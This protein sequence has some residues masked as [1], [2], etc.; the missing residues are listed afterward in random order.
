MAFYHRTERARIAHIFIWVCVLITMASY[1]RIVR[2]AHGAHLCSGRPVGSQWRLT[3][4]SRSLSW[5]PMSHADGRHPSAP[6]QPPPSRGMLYGPDRSGR[7]ASGWDKSIDQHQPH[8][9][10]GARTGMRDRRGPRPVAGAR[11]G[12]SV[13]G[14]SYHGVRSEKFHSSAMSRRMYQ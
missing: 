9:A 13:Q 6:M 5:P 2:D 8:S 14:D 1:H 7:M 11:P 4:D 10:S 3:V 12:C